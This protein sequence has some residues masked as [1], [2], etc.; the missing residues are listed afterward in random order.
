MLNV[1]EFE[2]QNFESLNFLHCFYIVLKAYLNVIFNHCLLKKKL[3]VQ[4]KQM[5]SYLSLVAFNK[6]CQLLIG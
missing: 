6:Y 2:F 1:F 5:L 3:T 4:A